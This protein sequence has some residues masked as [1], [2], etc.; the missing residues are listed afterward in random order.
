M[1]V[2]NPRKNMTAFS[3]FGLTLFYMK[4]WVCPT[5][6][7]FNISSNL[8]VSCPVPNCN[9][10][11]HIGLCKTC[12]TGYTLN[13]QDNPLFQC[14]LNCQLANCISCATPTVC[15]VCNMAK[16]YFVNPLTG[17]CVTC[18]IP[19]CV[20]CLTLSTCKTCDE[21]NDYFLNPQPTGPTDQCLACG[22]AF[23]LDCTSATICS[24]CD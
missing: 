3:R 9:V 14:T 6:T 8:C 1:P 19:Y 16:N 17:L 18:T 23:C 21:T 20:Q 11:Q 13:V 22:I 24:A 7:F 5:N 15:S 12:K 2:S 4:T 10:C